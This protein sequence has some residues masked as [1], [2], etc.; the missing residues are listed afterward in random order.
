MHGPLSAPEVRGGGF[1]KAMHP[2]VFQEFERICL[3]RNAGGAV[4]E[5]G[6]VPSD[7]SLLCLDS[8][9]R[10]KSKIGVNLEGPYTH[11][12]FRILKA[13]ANSLTCFE[14][15]SF[16]TVLTNATLEHDRFFWQTLS[17]IKRVTKEGGLIV[18]G[19]PGYTKLRIEKFWSLLNKMPVLR[20]LP[21]KYCSPLAASTLTQSIHLFPSDYYRF[22]PLAVRE[23]FFGHLQDVEISSLLIPPRIIGSGIKR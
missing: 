23:V 20:F 1:G 18:I 5:I 15:S 8:L 16:D 14:D 12:D 21:G 13:D 17:E 22:S 10:A 11:R 4:L 19:V 2:R 6:A 7:D 3:K 9:K